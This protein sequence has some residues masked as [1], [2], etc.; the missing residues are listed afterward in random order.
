MQKETEGLMRFPKYYKPQN[1]KEISVNR[2]ILINNYGFKI[3]SLNEK[4]EY[5]ITLL[6]TY[7]NGL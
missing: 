6:E 4:N 5:S 2:F 3:Y 1:I 7:Y